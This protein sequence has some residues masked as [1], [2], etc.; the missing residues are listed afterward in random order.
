MR[1]GR[2]RLDPES[3]RGDEYRSDLRNHQSRRAD[4]NREPPDY[5]IQNAGV[6]EIWLILLS[7]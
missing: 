4:S 6:G 2:F 1:A 7:T 3:D 5:K